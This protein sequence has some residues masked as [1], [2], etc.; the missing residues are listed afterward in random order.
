VAGAGVG[1]GSGKAAQWRGGAVTGH[2]DSR[3]LWW[4]HGRLACVIR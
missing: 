1:H 4:H 2:H 3:V